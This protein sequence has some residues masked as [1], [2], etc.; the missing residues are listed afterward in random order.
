MLNRYEG[1][2]ILRSLPGLP[3]FA[4][5]AAVGAVE[6][7][8][9]L[10][11]RG[12]PA[13]RA[14]AAIFFLFAAVSFFRFSRV[15]FGSYDGQWDKYFA[16]QKDL[17]A[18]GE[19]LRPRFEAADAVVVTGIEMTH[20]YI[21]TL[22]SLEYDPARWL[23]DTKTIVPGPLP[24][25]SYAHEDVVTRYGKVWFLFAGLPLPSV[26]TDPA[27]SGRRTIFIVRPG[28]L[29]LEKRQRPDFEVRSPR[30]EPVLWCFDV[31]R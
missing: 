9:W 12:R 21:D 17:L 3:I 10:A 15:F 4:L 28:E 18:A 2:S 11:K 1:M 24:D 13:A 29:G 5:L 19:W 22:V 7:F 31:R 14:V 16:F 23:A 30:D 20:P 8:G 27:M 6:A 25:G 26:L